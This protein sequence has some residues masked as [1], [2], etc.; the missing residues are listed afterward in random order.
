MNLAK[1]ITLRA[2]PA[3]IAALAVAVLGALPASA[4][5]AAQH[6]A[7]PAV[8]CSVHV[9]HNAPHAYYY[10]AVMTRNPCGRIVKP[11]I[12]A[13]SLGVKCWASGH[14]RSAKAPPDRKFRRLVPADGTAAACA[15]QTTGNTYIVEWGF[16]WRSPSNCTHPAACWKFVEVGQRP[17]PAAAAAPQAAHLTAAQAVR[18][19]GMLGPGLNEFQ[20]CV[21]KGGGKCLDEGSSHTVITDTNNGSNQ[22][23]GVFGAGCHTINTSGGQCQPFFTGTGMNTQFNAD[24]IVN[25]QAQNA[26]C[27]YQVSGVAMWN[28][29]NCQVTANEWVIDGWSLI[30]VTRSNTEG[31]PAYL[32]S[33]G[34]A[35]GAAVVQTTW[36]SGFCQLGSNNGSTAGHRH[37]LTRAQ[38]ASVL[39]RAHLT[40]A[41]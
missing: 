1:R 28:P 17:A 29:S 12:K 13:V 19:R 14:Q 24:K 37:H 41:G 30:N 33:Q 16:R 36:Q 34:I 9:R 15:F 5:P 31:V 25:V 18:P 6:G 10:D 3:G 39:T 38:A 32:C 22:R 26:A 7:A 11:E 4:A 23:W 21:T 8:D 2:L 35:G 27:L 20:V 40:L